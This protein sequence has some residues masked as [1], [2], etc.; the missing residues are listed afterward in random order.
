MAQPAPPET[1]AQSIA[2]ALSAATGANAAQARPQALGGRGVV[3]GLVLVAV[4]AAF[5][6]WLVSTI[7]E[8]TP[9][10]LYLGAVMLAAWYGGRAAGLL[11]TGVSALLGAYLFSAPTFTFTFALPNSRAWAQVALFALEGVLITLVTARLQLERRRAAAAALQARTALDKLNVVLAGVDDGILVQEGSG[12]LIYANEIGARMSGFATAQKLLRATPDERL[13]H[14]SLFGDDGQP[15]PLAAL[16]AR[17]LLSG[18]TAK[19]EVIC[20]RPSG[21]GEE[22]WILARASAVRDSRGQVLF[23]VTVARDVTAQRLHEES[24]RLSREWFS[25][26]LRSIGD[27]VITTDQKG[28]VTFCN[29]VAVALTG[30]TAASAIGKPLKEIFVIINETSRLPVDSPVQRVLRE[31]V[32]V[33]LANHTLLVRRDGVET[34]IDDSAAPIRSDSGAIDGVVLVFRDVSVKRREEQRKSFQARAT[35]E[36]NSSLDYQTTLATVARLAVPTIADWCAVDMLDGDQV[37]RLAVAHIDPAKIAFVEELER[38]Y[39]TDPNAQS[40]VPNVLRTGQPELVAD[41][42]PQMI[43]AAA[44]DADHLRLIQKLALRAYMAVPLKR[45]ARTIGV[46]VFAMAE[47]NRLYGPDDLALATSLADRAAI[48][49]ENALLFGEVERARAQVTAQRDRLYNLVMG[50]PIA[51]AVLSGTELTYELVNQPFEQ[52]FG[53]RKLQ[54][55]KVTELDPTGSHTSDLRRVRDTGVR[56]TDHEKAVE[57]DWHATGQPSTRYFSYTAVPLPGDAVNAPGVMVFTIEVTEQIL[58]RHKVE[59]ARRQAEL[60][61]RSKDE[62]LAM[63][64]HELR[65]PLA[66]ILTAL[67]LMHLRADGAL[68]RERAVIERQVKHVVRLVD[69]LL[70]ISRITR[71]KVELAQEP[72]LLAETVAKAIEMASPLIEQRGHELTVA[73]SPGLVVL[74]DPVRLAQIV[75][76]LLNN[77]AKYTERGGHIWVRGEL[78]GRTIRL[79]VRDSGMG[80]TPEMLTRVFELFAQEPQAIDRAQGGLGLGLAI[81]RSLVLLHGGTVTAHSDGRGKGSEFT[82]TL[83]AIEATTL[84]SAIS[85]LPARA[86]SNPDAARILVVDDNVDAMELLAEA[87]ELL[88]HETVRATD[89]PS[90]LVLAARHQPDIALLDIGLPVMDGYELGRRLRELGGLERI[91]LVAITGYGQDSDHERSAAAGFNGHLV[92]PVNLQAVQQLITKLKSSA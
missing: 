84:P 18:G 40:G 23:A 68:L 9:F 42:P 10:L 47:S 26:A 85:P 3:I 79:A 4:I 66:P 20:L 83:P 28:Q 82:V 29:P 90:A 12:Q 52:T 51:I 91:K 15:F 56:F 54:G 45:G 25:T 53:G 50:S 57:Y 1:S 13:R 7:G 21:D 92:K 27:A 43:E 35:Q 34:A 70:D 11:T 37:R 61:N 41:I 8:P 74:G 78:Q 88:G 44:I 6:P 36:L 71:G 76:N 63:L 60:A 39:P 5:K 48:A 64:G 46:I 24:L 49:V 33:G 77:A 38:N 80:I 81:V 69:D 65:N 14:Y 17:V 22:R 62:F 16:P 32:V 86:A 30:W 73:L 72:V 59:E 58:A 75:A 67:Q 55:L 31:G 87:L 89:G 19:E 2:E